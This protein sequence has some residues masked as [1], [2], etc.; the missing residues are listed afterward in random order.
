VPGQVA[1]NV[2]DD[3]FWVAFVRP[4]LVD[5]EQSAEFLAREAREMRLP[6]PKGSLVVTL[7]QWRKYAKSQR[8]FL[9]PQ[10]RSAAVIEAG[11]L[12]LDL[13]LIWDGGA[14]HNPN[15][16][17]TVFRHFDSASV[18]RG[19]VGQQPKTM[20]IIDYSLLERIHYLLVAGFDVYGAVG[21]QLESRLY[22]DFLRMEGE[23][24]FLLFLPEK[25]RLATRDH[26]YRDARNHVR[27]YLMS[28]EDAG[29]RRP[30]SIAYATDDPKSEFME[31]LRAHIPAAR[32]RRAIT[33]TPAPARPDG[34][35]E[36]QLRFMP[37]VAF[38]AGAG[39]AR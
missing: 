11:Q 23:Q 28:P 15:A 36:Q 8:R 9:R 18:V 35:A 34:C 27:D 24:A 6:Q 38:P 2:I 33:S 22:M 19:F 39:Q 16:A 31:M 21:H 13:D 14:Q 7:L 37:E 4:N 3:H 29:Y 10:A 30:S 17:L 1:L 26:W 5:P 32:G 25:Q 12:H 20:W